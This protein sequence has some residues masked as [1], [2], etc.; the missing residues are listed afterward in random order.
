MKYGFA[1]LALIARWQGP[2][3]QGRPCLE[4]AQALCKG[5]DRA[6]SDG[7]AGPLG[8]PAARLDRGSDRIPG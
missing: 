4:Q 6:R 5:G 8:S 3:V 7:S 1:R 2:A